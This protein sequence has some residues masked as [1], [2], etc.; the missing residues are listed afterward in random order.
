MQEKE[1]EW[2]TKAQAGDGDAFGQ[3]VETYQIPVFNLCYRML[4]NAQEAEDAAQETFL[5]AYNSMKSYDRQK[6]FSTWLLSIAAHYSID[7]IRRRRMTL[8]PFEALPYQ[9]LPDLAPTPE[10]AVTKIEEQRRVRDLLETLSP[11]DRAA[12]VMYYWHDLSYTQIAEAL[13]LT[14]SA[15][16]SR[17]HRARVEMA[18]SWTYQSSRHSIQERSQNGS[19]AF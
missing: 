1:V 8:V 13:D 15:V 4:G 6:P 17:L 12:V 9:D 3:L 7:Q 16:K 18:K 10:A 14:E 19:P 11:T 2:L 5:R